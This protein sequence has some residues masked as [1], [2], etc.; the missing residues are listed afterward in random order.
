MAT[1]GHDFAQFR[2][3]TWRGLVDNGSTTLGKILGETMRVPRDPSD[4]SFTRRSGLRN[5]GMFLAG[6]PLMRGQQDKFRDHSRVPRMDELVTSFDFESVAHAKLSEDAFQN[7]AL[8][9]E[10]EFTTR[11]NREVFDWV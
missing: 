9:A 10:G 1:V 11:R 8:G 7:T 6:S 3:G 2:L 5:L 4:L